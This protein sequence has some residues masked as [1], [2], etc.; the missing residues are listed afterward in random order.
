M[1]RRSFFASI[2]GAAGCIAVNP[3]KFLG[4]LTKAKTDKVSGCLSAAAI[5]GTMKYDVTIH[6]ILLYD[7]RK[8][9]R[10]ENP[11]IQIGSVEIGDSSIRERYRITAIGDW[12]ES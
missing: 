4:S 3:F 2:F 8:W 6:E 11:E 1:N 10:L 5:N 12:N 9:T 7:G